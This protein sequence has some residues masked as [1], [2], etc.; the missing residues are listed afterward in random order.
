MA[1]S[2]PLTFKAFQLNDTIVATQ[3]KANPVVQT[4]Q[5]IHLITL[6]DTS[7]SMSHDDKLKNVVTS[8]TSLLEHMTVNDYLSVITY[9]TSVKTYFK[10][11]KMDTEGKTE[12][13]HILST[14]E[15]NGMTNMSGGILQ[16]TEALLH[17]LS[18]KECILL[19]TDGFA[20]KGVT[21]VSELVD[22]IKTSV[23]KNPSLSYSTIGYGTDHNAQLLTSLATE[24]GGSYNVVNSLEDTA[25]V[26]GDV[27]GGLLSCVSQN[28][29]VTYPEDTE[30]YTSYAVHGNTVFI[31]DIQAEGEIYILTNKNPVK[32]NGYYLPG[33][34]LFDLDVPIQDATDTDKKSAM[35]AYLRY[36]VVSIMKS[37]S[38]RETRTLTS[39]EKTAIRE[40]ITAVK[41]EIALQSE[42]PIWPLLVKQ[43]D[44]CYNMLDTTHIS[45]ANLTILSQHSACIG[46][47][48]GLMSGDM[49]PVAS[50]FGNALQRN[51]S[52]G[53]RSVVHR[54]TASGYP[55]NNTSS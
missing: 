32:A 38:E 44:D 37:T 20:N 41:A 54:Q 47:G 7:T 55:V 40:K 31:G 24:G 29:T 6:I 36:K 14:L 46:T 8:L 2:N 52:S 13:R 15:P 18:I 10:Q 51:I 19:L 33:G 50:P 30:F 22:I 27:L 3:I 17:E 23:Q 11:K 34:I 53:M 16:G 28:V 25:T 35:I 45:H 39:E 48:R 42:S 21:E 4:R 9:D 5:P 12:T 26:F 1:S 43:L 49:D